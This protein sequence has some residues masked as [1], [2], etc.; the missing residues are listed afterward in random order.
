MP[1]EAM[2]MPM[3]YGGEMYAKGGKMPKEVLRA[4]AESHMSKE[5]ADKYVNNYGYG[6]SDG[7]D[8]SNYVPIKNRRGK[9]KGFRIKDN[10]DYADHSTRAL[11]IVDRTIFKPRFFNKGNEE[12]EKVMNAYEENPNQFSMYYNPFKYGGS[13]MYDNGGGK[14][15]KNNPNPKYWSEYAQD[16]L[17]KAEIGKLYTD[18]AHTYGTN[19]AENSHAFQILRKDYLKANPT[20]LQDYLQTGYHV[21]QNVRN[22]F[23]SV[24][25][26]NYK[27]GG[28]MIKRADG[29]YSQRGLWDNIRAT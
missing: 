29:S 22:T 21:A 17:T 19:R 20:L 12:W 4:R 7:P 2:G 10:S 13:N 24:F 15:E 14:D 16:Y 25:G 1:P 27:M 28:N 18:A 5:A 23:N 8:Y 3:M 26:T 9:V 6:G 11:P